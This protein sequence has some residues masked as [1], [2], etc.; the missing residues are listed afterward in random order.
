MRTIRGEVEYR[1]KFTYWD[2]S[3]YTG[4]W[5]VGTD[6]RQ[7][8]GVHVFA[9]GHKY[10]GQWKNDKRHGYGTYTW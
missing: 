1:S 5:L 9:N 2:G 10:D 7:G 8:R 3:H 6:K 4:E